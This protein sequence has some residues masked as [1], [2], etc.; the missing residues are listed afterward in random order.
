MTAATPTERPVAGRILFVLRGGY[1][2]GWID[3]ANV[4]LHAL[5]RRL[6]GIGAEPI[7]V[8]GRDTS[9][10]GQAPAQPAES[11]G[12]RVLRLAEPLRAVAEM[13]AHLRPA[14][15]VMRNAVSVAQAA[16]IAKQLRRPLHLYLSGGSFGDRLPAGEPAPLLRY[17]ANSRFLVR[18]S[19]LLLDAPVA[20]VPSIVEPE[21]FRCRPAGDAVLF[22]NPTPAKG[23]Q[24]AAALARLLPHRRFLFVRSWR[25]HPSFRIVEVRLPN[26]EWVP[27]TLDMRPVYARTKL[28]LMPSVLDE[29]FG[30]TAAEAQVSGIPCVVSDRG[31]L[32]ETAGPGGVV[33]PITAPI[34]QWRD[35]VEGVLADAGRH[36][37]LS[38]GAREHA[39]RPEAAP[40]RILQRF[41]D[42]AGA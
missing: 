40:E 1:L 2:P 3:G 30:R 26:V 35:T 13:A 17:A 12:Y 42:F 29:S 37:S 5:C 4:S 18:V 24:V 11:L 9:A 21:Q 32:P 6:L 38:R 20:H 23:V 33:V 7:V 22:V 25:D 27:S 19:E 39:A 34:E 41:L 36:A 10:P 8:C 28:V 14:A 16:E 31:G 15:I